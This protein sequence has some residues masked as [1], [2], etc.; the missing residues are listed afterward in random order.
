MAAQALLEIFLSDAHLI[1]YI[2]KGVQKSLKDSKS[3]NYS[4]IVSST[5]DQAFEELQLVDLVAT[6]LEKS[7][8]EAR[9]TPEYS[10]TEP[11]NPAKVKRKIKK[12]QEPPLSIDFNQTQ[13]ID[14]HSLELDVDEQSVTKESDIFPPPDSPGQN[15]HRRTES[16]SL[17]IGNESPDPKISSDRLKSPPS[18]IESVREES[19]PISSSVNLSENGHSVHEEDYSGSDF[20]GTSPEKSSHENENWFHETETKPKR[21]VNFLDG[22][23]SDTFVH[24]EKHAL[25]DVPELFYT[26]DESMKFQYD[27]DREA[28]RAD[29]DGVSWLDWMMERTEEERLKHE[30]EDELHQHEYQ[31]YWEGNEQY[32]EESQSGDEMW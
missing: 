8:S 21:T 10:E 18:L 14:P 17:I 3:Q 30:E 7:L 27:Y 15:Q 2:S 13:Y 12:E 4:K 32:E 16:E 31:D 5:I 9:T 29:S 25:E 11:T 19:R 1:E 20:E 22:L 28:Q 26:Q 24:R 6:F 23:V